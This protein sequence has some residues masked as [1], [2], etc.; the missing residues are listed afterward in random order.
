MVERI[1]KGLI[2]VGVAAVLALLATGA[3][4]NAN[5]GALVLV[6]AVAGSLVLVGRRRR[7]LLVLTVVTAG[8]F[9]LAF[10]DTSALVLSL[11]VALYSVGAFAPRRS[12]LL[13]AAVSL[14]TTAA[15]FVIDDSHGPVSSAPALA[16]LAAAWVFGDNA[17]AR[18]ERNEQRARDALAHERARIARELHD[19]ITHNVSVMVVQAAAGNAAF[20]KQPERARE[21]LAAVEETGR[22]ALGELRRLLDVVS[23]D[24]GDGTLPQPGLARLDE[25]VDRVRA[26]GL[27][28]DLAVTGTPRELP[29]GVD[30]SAYRI[31]QEALTNTL[32]HAKATR[33]RVLVRYER[34]VLELDVTDDGV[35]GQSGSNGRGL[36]GMRERTALFGGE[37]RAGAAPGGGFAVRARMPAGAA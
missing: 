27:V 24:D 6:A 37:L 18:A 14:A 31:V 1:P 4:V 30:L 12:S 29:P 25:L 21:A 15:A 13:A 22:Q 7:P 35:G 2:D 16:F 11:M 3:V 8:T 10:A 33:V 28:V 34:D 26:A 32:K 17:R 36:V 9:A 19:V 20:S 5:R 23:Y